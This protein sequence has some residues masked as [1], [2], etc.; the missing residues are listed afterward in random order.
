MQ[1]VCLVVF[2]RFFT[3][4]FPPSTSSSCRTR[5]QEY[6]TASPPISASVSA[7]IVRIIA[8][9]FFS[10]PTWPQSK[11][12]RHSQSGPSS[13]HIHVRLI[14]SRRAVVVPLTPQIP[15]SPPLFIGNSMRFRV[16][17]VLFVLRRGPHSAGGSSFPAPGLFPPPPPP[18]SSRQRLLVLRHRRCS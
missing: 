6:N 2:R 9:Q 1:V 16:S 13:C 12:V 14:R 7:V 3:L 11:A 5:S 18:Q 10:F 15:Q 17:S 8:P 4:A